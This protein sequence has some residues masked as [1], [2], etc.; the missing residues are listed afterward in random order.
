MRRKR[1]RT[2]A[3][4]WKEEEEEVKGRHELENLSSAA[5]REGVVNFSLGKEAFDTNF[6]REIET[7]EE[8]VKGISKK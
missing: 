4:V 1:R 3:S 7:D 8:E 5:W 6:L 2:K